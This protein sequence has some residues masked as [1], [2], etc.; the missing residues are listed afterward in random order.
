MKIKIKIGSVI[1]FTCDVSP[2][3]VGASPS[4]IFGACTLGG[5]GVRF[6]FDLPVTYVTSF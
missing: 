2:A 3:S 5:I 6:P 4:A 1:Y